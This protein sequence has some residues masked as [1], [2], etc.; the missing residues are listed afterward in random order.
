MK[1]HVSLVGVTCLLHSIA[2]CSGRHLISA[3]CGNLSS[4]QPPAAC[5]I[6]YLRRV[7]L[8]LEEGGYPSRVLRCNF[9]KLPPSGQKV[10]LRS[11]QAS[12][13]FV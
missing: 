9:S 13:A 5:W 12:Q 3:V 4:K 1:A 2:R 7:S 11:F 6:I 8:N 10:D